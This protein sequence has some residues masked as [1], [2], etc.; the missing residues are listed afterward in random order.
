MVVCELQQGFIVQHSKLR[1]SLLSIV[2]LFFAAFVTGVFFQLSIDVYQNNKILKP[3]T[4]TTANIE[5]ISQL[6]NAINDTL[7]YLEEYRWEYSDTASLILRV[8]TNETTA[9][10]HLAHIERD[11]HKTGKEQ[12]VL[13]TAID[14]TYAQFT[15]FQNQLLQL[16]LDAKQEESA[17][18]YYDKIEPCGS[19]LKKYCQELLELAILDNYEIHASLLKTNEKLNNLQGIMLLLSLSFGS[20]MIVS[21][22]RLMMFLKQMARASKNISSGNLLIPDIQYKRHDEMG[23]LISAFN[24]M[25]HSMKMQ[26][27][28]LEEKNAMEKELLTKKNESLVLQN[29]L[30]HEKMQQLHSRINPHFL[31]NTINVIKYTAQEENATRTESLLSSLGKIYRYVLATDSLQLSLAHEIQIVN[32]FNTLYSK[33]FSN[34]LQITWEIAPYLDVTEIIIPSFI[35]QPLVENAIKHGLRQK[36]E[37]GMIVVAIRRE[38]NVLKIQVSDNGVGMSAGKLS[39]VRQ[40]LEKLPLD[41]MHIG[42]YNVAA[43]LKLWQSESGLDI[44]SQE[45]IGTT[46]YLWMPLIIEE[47]QG[48][49]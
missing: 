13:V 42:L 45:G 41:G 23:I 35:I 20:V 21:L 40:N 47:I 17:N 34:N 4:E 19:Y 49:P 28:L 2:I 38:L 9:K 39:K 16:M 14:T 31:F 15:L 12:Y 30:E 46:T 6:L 25:K 3:I 24:E 44:T 22:F 36:E 8:R 32:E 43:R 27:S 7:S 48:V 10:N 18:L 37:E 11:L 5:S 29:L 33:R 1:F 26:V